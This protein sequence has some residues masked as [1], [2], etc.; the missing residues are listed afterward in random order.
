MR[1]QHTSRRFPEQN[2]PGLVFVNDS[3]EPLRRSW[4]SAYVW[5]PAVKAA[6]LPEGTRF[7][8]LRHFYA[9][10]LIRQGESVMVVQSRLGHATAAETLD[11]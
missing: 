10:L 3:G 7:H 4:F 1:S 8:D 2:H 5:R 11:T 6:A 9:S